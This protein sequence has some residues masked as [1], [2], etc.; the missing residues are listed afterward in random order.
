MKVEEDIELFCKNYVENYIS[1]EESENKQD[2][3]NNFLKPMIV[4]GYLYE[5]ENFQCS[6][7]LPK[8]V[9]NIQ[10]ISEKECLDYML[11]N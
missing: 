4:D 2:Y 1:L 6:P 5:I 3:I 9:D 7:Y 8:E 11:R 10:I